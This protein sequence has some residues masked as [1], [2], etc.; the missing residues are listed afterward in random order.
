MTIHVFNNGDHLEKKKKKNGL[1][2]IVRSLTN[3][4]SDLGFYAAC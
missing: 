4:R 2:H 3:Q 1:P